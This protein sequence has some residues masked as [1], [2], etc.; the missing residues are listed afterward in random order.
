[1]QGMSA[2]CNQN[3]ALAGSGGHVRN[4]E[5]RSV[6]FFFFLF[7]FT[8]GWLAFIYSQIRESRVKWK[9]RKTH[10]Y[11]KVSEGSPCTRNTTFAADTDSSSLLWYWLLKWR[12]FLL[13]TFFIEIPVAR[14]VNWKAFPLSH[15][16]HLIL[17]TFCAC[18]FRLEKGVL[19]LLSPLKHWV[20]AKERNIIYTS[21]RKDRCYLVKT[22][23]HT[24]L[25]TNFCFF[26]D[27]KVLRNKHRFSCGTLC[28]R[29]TNKAHECAT[30]W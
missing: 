18:C 15:C 5:I 1:M 7:L 24:Y 13:Q 26:C 19:P 29:T 20:L 14:T 22:K 10:V 8:W 9:R 30:P 25:P 16:L 17:A 23:T 2:E 27:Q 6:F 4:R 21:A 3:C 28:G 11:K 12:S